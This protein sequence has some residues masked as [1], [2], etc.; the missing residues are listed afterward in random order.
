MQKDPSA[1]IGT[2]F[3]PRPGPVPETSRGR[4]PEPSA[5]YTP[6]KAAYRV[7][8]GWHRIVGWLGVAVGVIIAALNDGMYITEIRLLPF[9]H[10]E[11]YLMLAVVVA[12]WSARFL[13]LFDRGTTIFE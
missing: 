11:L 10:S 13:G 1:E 9:G 3:P 5:R 6:A 8:P 12:G 7:R 2:P 4:P